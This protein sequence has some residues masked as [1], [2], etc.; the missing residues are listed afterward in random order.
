MSAVSRTLTSLVA[1]LLA[2]LPARAELLRL[3]GS[4]VV[5]APMAAAA[6]PL[7]ALGIEIKITTE[8]GSGVAV[9]AVG[10]EQAE[11]AMVTREANAEERAAFPGKTFSEVPIGIQALAIIVPR[12]VWEAGVRTITKAQ[13]IDIYEGRITNWKQLGG[14]DRALKFYNGERGRGVWEFFAFWLYGD[15]RKAPL[16]KKFETVVDGED[17][18]NTV[19]FNAGSVSLAAPSWA[20]GK[21]VFALGIKDDDGT[22]AEPTPANL[23]AKKYPLARPAMLVVA[24]KPL[25][26]LKKRVIDFML[27]EPGQA[28]VKKAGLIPMSELV[29]KE[30]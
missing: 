12:D 5:A 1:A 15:I 7:K 3:H 17:A 8:G 26:G 22:V 18:R 23:L 16:G 27:S 19:E 25:V 21:G 29:P 6:A 13:M 24:Q 11:I 9:M 30:P 20:D 14:E 2:A 28:I 4:P 10:A